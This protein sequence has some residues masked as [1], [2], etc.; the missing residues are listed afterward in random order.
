MRQ[1]ITALVL[2][3]AVLVGLALPQGSAQASISAAAAFSTLGGTTT[4]DSGGAIHSQARSIYSLGGGMTSFTGKKVTFLAADPPSFSA[5]CAGISWHFGGFAFI[6]MDELRQMV[7]AISQASLGVAVD[8][9]M[10]V[11][12]PQCYAVM[13][14]LRDIA[15]AMRNAAADSCKVAKNLGKMAGS[16]LSMGEP[17]QSKCAELS[18][19]DGQTEGFL[20]SIAGSMCRG[21]NSVQNMLNTHG[22][23]MIRFLNGEL[24][25]GERTPDAEMIET[26]YNYHYEILSALGYQDGVLKDLL[27]N[28]TGMTIYAPKAAATCQEVLGNLNFPAPTGNTAAENKILESVGDAPNTDRTA[29]LANNNTSPANPSTTG[30]NRKFNVC[31]APPLLTGVKDLAFNLV[32]GFRRMDDAERFTSKYFNNNRAAMDDSSIGQFCQYRQASAGGRPLANNDADPMLYTCRAGA[33]NTARCVQPRQARYSAMISASGDEYSGL[34]WYIA[35]A[36]YAGA[37]AVRKNQP[38]PE[39]TVGILSGSGYPL[40]RLINLAA[41]YPGMTDNLLSAYSTQI[42]IQYAIDTLDKLARPGS[43]PTIE[44][45]GAL[46]S[47]SADQIL[48]LRETL[49]NM[50]R[51]GTVYK[52]QT[53][54][55]LSEK[56]ALVQSIIEINRALQSEVI[57]KGLS[58]NAQMALSIKQQLQSNP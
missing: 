14:K 2:G 5:G 12:C 24:G 44:T 51:E 34:V 48:E 41:V 56:R 35:D 9:A 17:A 27:L 43:M 28:M 55:V 16:F 32:C 22:D 15:N 11:L 40:Y 31:H 21:M 53:M 19:S 57:S 6:S 47:I 26:T 3:A 49:A 30:T 54:K 36:L 33:G 29:Q 20:G 23:K 7:E 58:G 39:R 1:F 46:T 45:R 4:I 50:F 13:S 42:A 52:D 18:S 38:L 10:Q 37:E 8:L 25:A